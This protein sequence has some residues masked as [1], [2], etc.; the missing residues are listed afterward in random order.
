LRRKR[1]RFATCP[2]EATAAEAVGK[3][4]AAERTG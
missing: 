1:G 2:E 4:D 3:F